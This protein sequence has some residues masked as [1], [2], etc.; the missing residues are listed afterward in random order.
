M[1]TRK[2]QPQPQPQPHS[3]HLFS[4]RDKGFIHLQC[5]SMIITRYE[6]KDIGGGFAGAV[7]DGGR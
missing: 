1:T 7:T 3:T 6:D 2:Q 5:W 4:R